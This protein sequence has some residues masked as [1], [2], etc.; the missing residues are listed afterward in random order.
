VCAGIAVYW[1]DFPEAL[2][3]HHLLEE[4]KVL[5]AE[6]AEPEVQFLFRAVPRVIPAWHRGRLAVFPWG[7]GGRASPLPPGGWVRRAD[8][9]AGRVEAFQPELVDIP[10]C[11]GLDKGVWYQIHEGVHGL[12]LRDPDGTPHVYLLVEPASHY[13]QTMTRSAWMPLLIGQRI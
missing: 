12:L 10:A 7:D 4:R 11:F 3:G 9:E 5:R 2:L 6:G 1:R 8:L 13:Y